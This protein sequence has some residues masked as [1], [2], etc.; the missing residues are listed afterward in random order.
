MKV[1]AFDIKESIRFERKQNLQ[2]KIMITMFA[3]FAE[4]ERDLISER[5]KEGLANAK[6]KANC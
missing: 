2:S 5:T 6:Q 3:L 1:M 4:V